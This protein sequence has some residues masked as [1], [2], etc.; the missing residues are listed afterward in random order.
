[1]SELKSV[2]QSLIQ[3]PYFNIFQSLKLSCTYGITS[4]VFK[5]LQIVFGQFEKWF[6]FFLSDE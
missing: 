3:T 1:M 2:W 5:D 4:S 6:I